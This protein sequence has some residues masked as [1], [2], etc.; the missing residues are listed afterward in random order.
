L[1]FTT[2]VNKTN[3]R[4]I[5]GNMRK[6]KVVFVLFGVAGITETLN[7]KSSNPEAVDMNGRFQMQGGKNWILPK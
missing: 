6:K 3:L 2:A 7:E 4:I 5:S 1:L